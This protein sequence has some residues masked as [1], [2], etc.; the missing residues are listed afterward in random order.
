[1]LD[2]FMLILPIM[3]CVLTGLFLKRVG[4]LSDEGGEQ[5]SRLIFY[6]AMPCM[7]FRFSST[8][9][10][11][12][13]ADVGYL[14]VLYGG[15]LLTALSSWLVGLFSGSVPARRAASVSMSV[16]SNNVF[17]GYPAVLTLWGESWSGF[18]GRYIALSILGCEILSASAALITLNG[19]L[20]PKALC[21][22]MFSLFRNPFVIS[23]AV[24][25]V[26]GMGLKLPVPRFL[27]LSIKIFGDL[28]TGLALMLL[29]MKLQPSKLWRDFLDTWPDVAVRL[30]LSPLI[31]AAGYRLFPAQPEM[32]KIAVLVMAMPVAMNALPMAD[33]MGMDGDYTARATMTSTA[34]SVLTLPLVIRFLL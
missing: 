28:G 24:A 16:R 34:A 20:R 7:I 12:D 27:E 31:L 33:A 5:M 15:Y 17:M 25:L 3:C 19:S 2:G 10:P 11:S 18:Y 6:V 22:V 21:R 23:L 26:W 4:I 30:A 9:K 29:G 1:M 32:V 13:F 14:A 8:L